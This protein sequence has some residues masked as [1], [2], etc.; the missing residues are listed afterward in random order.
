MA[1]RYKIVSDRF[2]GYEEF[3][4][5]RDRFERRI[6]R[7]SQRGWELVGGAHVSIARAQ[8]RDEGEGFEMF[9]VITQT[10]RREDN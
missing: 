10:L 7:H 5:H 3:E 9:Y 6:Q 1:F 8:W 4:S 2:K